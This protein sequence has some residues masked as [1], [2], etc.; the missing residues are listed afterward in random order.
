M[1]QKGRHGN[2]GVPNSQCLVDLALQNGER[3]AIYLYY[4][5]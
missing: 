5:K 1:G 3:D 4:I 2:K